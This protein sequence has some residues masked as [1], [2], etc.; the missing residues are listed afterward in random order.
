MSEN[1]LIEIDED[2]ISVHPKTPEEKV[3]EKLI[4]LLKTKKGEQPADLEYGTELH[5]LIHYP[6]KD[7]VTRAATAEVRNAVA[8]YMSYVIILE[9]TT[10]DVKEGSGLMAFTVRYM[11][12]SNFEDLAKFSL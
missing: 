2:G 12:G 5:T 7:A 11:L 3:K 4:I 9:V 10:D 6:V 8:T 1:N